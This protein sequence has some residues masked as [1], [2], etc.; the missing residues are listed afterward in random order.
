MLTQH[1]FLQ[2]TLKVNFVLCK[3]EVGF[4]KA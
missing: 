3:P 2:G 1:L 4:L